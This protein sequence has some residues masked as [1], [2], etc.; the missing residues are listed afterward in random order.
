[1]RKNNKIKKTLNVKYT[2]EC[3]GIILLNFLAA[4]MTIAHPSLVH[5]KAGRFCLDT[6]LQIVDYIVVVCVD[7]W[8]TRLFIASD[9]NKIC[10]LA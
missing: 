7:S 5:M 2:A 1:V 6:L 4:G 10:S 8:D 3:L 9:D